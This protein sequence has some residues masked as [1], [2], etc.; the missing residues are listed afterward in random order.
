[1]LSRQLR[2]LRKEKR[3]SQKALAEAV[4]VS[5]QTIA[6][7]ETGRTHPNPQTL[8]KLADYFHVSTDFLLGRESPRNS[9]YTPLDKALQGVDFAL[10]GEVKQLSEAEK[11]DILD[12]I[13]FKKS[14]RR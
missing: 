10:W 9:E 7:W 13:Q 14:Q 12:F 5:Q 2:L 3:I 1:M 11:K 8:K 6:S 4:Q